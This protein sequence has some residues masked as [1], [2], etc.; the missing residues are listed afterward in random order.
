MTGPHPPPG[1]PAWPTP[2]RQDHPQRWRTPPFAAAQA[3]LRKSTSAPGA[4]PRCA[5]ATGPP[6]STR[7]HRR[8]VASAPHRHGPPALS[9][10]RPDPPPG[11]ALR[12][13]WPRPADLTA[14]APPLRAKPTAAVHQPYAPAPTPTAP[15]PRGT[16]EPARPAPATHPHRQVLHQAR[17]V[18]PHLIAGADRP[19]RVASISVDPSSPGENF[20]YVFKAARWAARAADTA[21]S[22]A[23]PLSSPSAGQT[24]VGWRETL[25]PGRRD[26]TEFLV[27]QLGRT[28]PGR[29][30]L[31]LRHCPAAAQNPSRAP[32][33]SLRA[34]P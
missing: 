33:A 18:R 29:R 6:P 3:P 13:A 12:P 27:A 20:L 7:P 1:A 16:A 24:P 17:N 2:R 26:R 22:P 11:S 14:V 21:A 9:A 31:P 8:V 32:S 5:G 23:L 30:W 28:R 4:Q 15:P 19:G 25:S 10:V 34:D